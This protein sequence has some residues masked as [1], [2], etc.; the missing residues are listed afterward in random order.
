M[1]IDQQG[2]SSVTL[3]V[4]VLTS[5]GDQVYL[6]VAGLQGVYIVDAEF[7]KL[8][9]RSGNEWRD[10]SV[11]SFDN[12]TFD[13]IA[14][15][16]NAKAFVL[17]LDHTNGLWRMVWPR[18]PARA[19]SAKLWSCLTNLQSLRIR[20]F[21]SD[22]SKTDLDLYGLATPDLQ[23]AIGEGTNTV[24]LLQFGKSPT[25]AT[26]QVYTRRAGQSSVFTVPNDPIAPWRRSKASMGKETISSRCSIKGA[27]SGS[28]CPPFLPIASW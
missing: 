1:I 24:E 23:L 15:T 21:V 7:L 4:G 25:N 26:S 6:Q 17:E 8:V 2:G 9:P 16:N 14:V 3:F 5:P 19:D 11:I 27:I 12:R 20:Q 28:F 13:R 10:T 18:P 22:N